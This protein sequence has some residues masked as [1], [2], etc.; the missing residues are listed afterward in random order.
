MKRTQ[1]IATRA[2][3][4]FACFALFGLAIVVRMMLV[5]LNP[6]YAAGNAMLPQLQ[7]I[8]PERGRIFSAEGHLLAASVPRF[9]LHWD[10]TVINTEAERTEFLTE[11]PG[12]AAACAN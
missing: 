10:P 6:D 7:T 1:H 11:L 3:V 4:L 5:Q 12:L 8:E 2:W 9:D